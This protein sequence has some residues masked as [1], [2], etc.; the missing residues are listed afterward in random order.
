MKTKFGISVMIVSFLGLTQSSSGQMGM[1]GYGM[2]GMGYGGGGNSADF[3]AMSAFMNCYS[4]K[5]DCPFGAGTSVKG[6][7]GVSY[8]FPTESEEYIVQNLVYMSS[9]DETVAENMKS[10][11]G[12][13]KYFSD[14]DLDIYIQGTK[15]TNDFNSASP[16]T[17]SR[18]ETQLALLQKLNS[19]IWI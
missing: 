18:F 15:Y 2:G 19:K 5:T 6:P 3:N 13:E 12:F 7:D 14:S 9:T 8:N 1:G 16:D 17:K 4:T 11:S 10:N